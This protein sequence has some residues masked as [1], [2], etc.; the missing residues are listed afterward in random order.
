[1]RAPHLFTLP[2]NTM[3]NSVIDMI[4][5]QNEKTIEQERENDN[6]GRPTLSEGCSQRLNPYYAL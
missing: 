4:L 5:W 2:C 6:S 1:M 3:F